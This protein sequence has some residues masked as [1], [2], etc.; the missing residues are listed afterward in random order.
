VS[1]LSQPPAPVRASR[2]ALIRE[3]REHALVIEDVIL[4]SGAEASYFIDAKRVILRP[5]GFRL[6]SEQIQH[7]VRELGATAVGGLTLGAD[8]IACAALVDGP[9]QVKGFFV[10]KEPKQH[11]LQRL[12]EGP[13]L[14]PGDR[15]LIVEDVVTSGA[16]TIKAI[17]AIQQQG[18]EICGVLAVLDRLAGGGDA[19]AA[20][21][22][23][24]FTALSTIDD[25]YPERPDR[26]VTRGGARL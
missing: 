9:A 17:R 12:I 26:S 25:V 19:I 7:Y 16:S 23:A 5:F 14:E 1:T 8:A 24:P 11:G 20:A 10:R 3:L 18:L 6:L 21:V 13:L 4:S 15:C 2:E 22:Q